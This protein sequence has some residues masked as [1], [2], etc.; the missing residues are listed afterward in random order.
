MSL[1]GTDGIRAR[2]GQYPL[3]APSLIRLGR[4]LA[5]R[6]RGAR[7]LFARD[8]RRS[9]PECSTLLG[10]GLSRAVDRLDLGIFPT[11]GLSYVLSRSDHDYG[12]MI[13][14]SH[15]PYQDNGIKIFNGAG[16]K[17]ASGEEREI[18]EDFMREAGRDGGAATDAGTVPDSVPRSR[19]L[20]SVYV[21]FLADQARTIAGE[22]A[23]CVLDCANGATYDL[24][25][26]VFEESEMTLD[27]INASPD[28][29]NI[30]A[31]CGSTD[32]EGL[33]SRVLDRGAEVGIAFDGDGDRVMF[34]DRRGRTI[35]GDHAL[36][37][38]G[39]WLK[40]F[41]G[42]IFKPVVV[43]TV[44]SNM[45]MELSLGKMGVK[46][47]RT[48]VGDK[49]VYAG[50]KQAGGILGGEPSGHV[51]LGHLQRTGDGILTAI[52]LLRALRD[53]N[54]PMADVIERVGLFPQVNHSLGIRNRRDLDS[55]EELQERIADF[56]ARL[57]KTARLVV[58][59]SGTE[60]K[61]R[62][63][64]EARDASIIE[65][66]LPPFVEFFQT[67]IGE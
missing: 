8:T 66:N 41:H 21:A 34:V 40:R 1:F 64:M 57:G 48:D 26:R 28:G 12:V 52:C 31:G 13:T 5:R 17:L 9:G 49:Q 16:E 63:M 23:H 19:E 27:V 35:G 14:A 15:N 43:G 32:L 59:Y 50:M 54:L 25:P 55:W 29:R 11:P 24:A 58:R 46:L 53:L 51:I 2:A 18:E 65:E 10:C 3:D 62:L 38:I 39:E 44:L 6:W 30:N 7:V 37:V 36:T 4:V 45:G 61:I 22:A 20:R 33:S 67:H 47:M 56:E 60:A 42:G